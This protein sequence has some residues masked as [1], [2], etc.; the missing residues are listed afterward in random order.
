MFMI[1]ALCRRF[2]ICLTLLGSSQVFAQ[3]SLFKAPR[4]AEAGHDIAIGA[5]VD[6]AAK[7]VTLSW[8]CGSDEYQAAM[9]TAGANRWTG[10]IPAQ[11]VQGTELTYRVAVGKDD[12]SLITSPD[13]TLFIC[14]QYTVLKPQPLALQQTVVVEKEWNSDDAAFGLLTPADGP[15]LGPAAI[16]GANGILYVLDSVKHRV[17]GFTA[18]GSLST[19][20]EVPTSHA[21]DLII[22][23]ADNSVIVVSQLE[24]KIHKFQNGRLHEARSAALRKNFEYPA[25]FSYD[26]DSKKL[27]APNQN[28]PEKLAAANQTPASELVEQPKDQQV[29]AEVQGNDLILKTENSSNVLVLPFDQPVGYIDETV[30]DEN[31]IVWVL[32]TL[33]GDYRIRRLARIDT[34][35]A[36]A[37]TTQINVWFSFDAT[38]RMTATPAGVALMT[39]DTSHGRIVT[40]DY[41][42][43]VQ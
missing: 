36:R 6:D 11:S 39:G 8:T 42:G 37:E 27:Y 23:P 5:I 21:S 26:R 10:T 19:T 9:T 1:N 14:P 31:G 17:L 4:F 33:E 41:A 35:N 7:D 30:T 13:V 43:D 29:T 20:I 22:D 40:F 25:K 38:R 3:V 16:A 15:P 34:L 28:H 32:Y 18:D 12:Q 24:D 2:L